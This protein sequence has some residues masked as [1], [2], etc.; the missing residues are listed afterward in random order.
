MDEGLRSLAM[1]EWDM[2]MRSIVLDL[3]HGDLGLWKY[4]VVPR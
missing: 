2:A 3:Q 4:I 1:V